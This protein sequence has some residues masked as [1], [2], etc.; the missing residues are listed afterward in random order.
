L[1][2]GDGLLNW[3]IGT[4]RLVVGMN[5]WAESKHTSIN[6]KKGDRK[7]KADSH[8]IRRADLQMRHLLMPF[9][10]DSTRGLKFILRAIHLFG[11]IFPV[12]RLEG[13]QLRMQRI[14]RMVVRYLNSWPNMGGEFTP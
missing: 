14:L 9:Q 6:E 1:L 2:I 8:A 10:R 7:D 4:Q 13:L 3:D 5:Q 11:Q 12:L